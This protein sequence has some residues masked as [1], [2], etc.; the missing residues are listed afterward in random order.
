MKFETRTKSREFLLR[1]LPL[2]LYTFDVIGWNR[3]VFPQFRM[4]ASQTCDKIM[5]SQDFI[6]TQ[7]LEF[8]KQ[9]EYKYNCL[10]LCA[11]HLPALHT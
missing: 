3:N 2:F 8:P 10:R 7:E 4:A 1:V 6:W 5:L 11:G 9:W